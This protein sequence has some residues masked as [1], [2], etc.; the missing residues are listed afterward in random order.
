MKKLLFAYLILFMSCSYRNSNVQENEQRDSTQLNLIEETIDIDNNSVLIFL[1][2]EYAGELHIFN[3]S[4]H[5]IKTI[6]NDIQNENFVM[7]ELLEKNDSMFRVTAFWSLD[8]ALIAEGWIYKNSHL[9][10]FSS[11]YNDDFILYEEPYNRKEIVV[12]DKGYNPEMYEVVDFEGR[13]LKIKAQI[14]NKIYYGWIPPEFQC[15]NVYST[16]N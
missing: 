10:I 11:T 4:H 1:D 2:C 14:K 15:S 5:R 8:N 13:W 3:D 16:C 12:I 7:F 6:K 9:G